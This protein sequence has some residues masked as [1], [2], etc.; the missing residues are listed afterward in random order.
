MTYKERV[1]VYLITTIVV[2]IIMLLM[3]SEYP[4]WTIIL[5]LAILLSTLIYNFY[6]W[7]IKS[8]SYRKNILIYNNILF[9]IIC[10]LV[11]FIPYNISTWWSII[12]FT[13]A[14][15]ASIF[16]YSRETRKY[17]SSQQKEL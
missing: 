11:F 3:P 10:Y 7:K 9:I 16:D 6:K 8:N 1:K 2:V 5:T 12:Y 4:L 14:I 15:I 17:K 13:V